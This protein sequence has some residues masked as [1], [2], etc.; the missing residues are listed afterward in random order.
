MQDHTRTRPLID[1]ALPDLRAIRRD[2]H[3]HPEIAYQEKRTSQVV[4]R[5]LRR[6]GIPFEA[7]RAGGTGVVAHLAATSAADN[8]KPAVGLRA[9]MDALPITEAT[10]LP[11]AS[12]NPGFMHACGHDGHTTI[13]LGAARVLK[14]LHRPRPITLVFQP[15]EEGGAGGKRLCDEGLIEGKIIGPRIERMYGLH[16][17]PEFDLGVIGT[18]PGPLLASTD[19]M[20]VVITG[21]PSHAAQP[22]YARDPIV[23]MAACISACQTVVSR[24]TSPFDSVVVSICLANGGTARNIIPREAT[25]QAT[26]RCL[27]QQTRDASRERLTAIVTHTAQAHGCTAEVSW[28]DGYP[29]THNDPKL[30]DDFFSLADAWLGKDR[31][32]RVETPTM[33]GEDFSFYAQQVPAVF[34]CLGLKPKG[35]DR[36]PYLHQP[37]FDFNDDAIPLGVEAF[38][39][40]ATS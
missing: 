4:Q 8:A 23:A 22:H 34:F 31:V 6:L 21:V 37:D 18:R 10:G 12:T 16:G 36:Y 7:G 2:L 28:H 17:W 20:K 35:K 39:R 15:A 27:L 32:T 33:G 14:D 29:V 40:L 24:N 1:A 13:L 38:C 19:E 5:E 26:L 25:F 9:D 11:Y 30:T 3:A